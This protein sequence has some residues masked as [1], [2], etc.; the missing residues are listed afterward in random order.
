MDLKKGPRRS[1]RIKDLNKRVGGPVSYDEVKRKVPKDLGEKCCQEGIPGSMGAAEGPEDEV[2]SEDG[3]ALGMEVDD[4]KASGGPIAGIVST[5]AIGEQQLF[6]EEREDLVSSTGDPP[7]VQVNQLVVAAQL[8]VQDEVEGP[9]SSSGAAAKDQP[10]GPF[11]VNP[12]NELLINFLLQLKQTEQG[13][14]GLPDEVTF[15]KANN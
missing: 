12:L 9:S 15:N 5:S 2:V 1:E 10:E 11:L 14:E 8:L 7:Q 3:N 4:N 6:A 13:G